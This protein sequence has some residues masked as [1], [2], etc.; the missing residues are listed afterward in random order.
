MTNQWWAEM[1]QRNRE[2]MRALRAC[3]T[4]AGAEVDRGVFLAVASAGGAAR[5]SGNER[6]TSFAETLVLPSLCGGVFRSQRAGAN[7]Q[8]RVRHRGTLLIALAG[9]G[10]SR[11]AKNS[12]ITRPSA[13]AIAATTAVYA[14][15]SQELW[16]RGAR[17]DVYGA[18]LRAGA[19]V[20]G[21]G[22]AAARAPKLLSAVAI[23]GAAAATTSTLAGADSLRRGQPIATQGMSHGANLLLAAEAVSLLR[24]VVCGENRETAASRVLAAGEC[25]V[26][27]I[28][29]MLLID[30]LTRN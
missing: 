10:V 12:R 3:L 23:A 15:L 8:T 16:R 22:L 28:G 5:L 14:G 21:C 19:W 27:A 2:G 17:A 11:A 25:G 13:W 1:A 29:A 20:T 18:S 7:T 24:A 4:A 6:A 26:Q 9:G 30:G